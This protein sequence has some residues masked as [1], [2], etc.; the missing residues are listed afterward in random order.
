MRSLL[1]LSGAI[2]LC[3]GGAQAQDRPVAV[4]A[5]TSGTAGD[6]E[7]IETATL[8]NFILPDPLQ[9]KNGMIPSPAVTGGYGAINLGLD[10]DGNAIEGTN[11]ADIAYFD[12]T[13]YLYGASSACGQFSYALGGGETTPASH[14]RMCGLTIYSSDDLMNWRFVS[15]VMP[16]DPATGRLVSPGKSRVVYSPATKM[17][18]MWFSKGAGGSV[19]PHVMQSSTPYGPWS[20]PRPIPDSR[21]LLRGV[22]VLDIDLGSDPDGNTWMVSSHGAIRVYK[23]ND[24]KTDIVEIVNVPVDLEHLNGGIGIHH[25]NGWWYVTGGPSC[26]NC[27]AAPFTYVMARDPSGPWISPVTG[28]SLGTIQPAILSQDSGN[29]QSNG[30]SQLP[31]GKGGF[32]TVV[33]FKHYIATA[34]KAPTEHWEQPGDV[35][36]GL[37]G[38]WFY[39]LTYG[40]DGKIQPMEIK[41]EYRFPLA[42]PVHS[43]GPPP[44]YQ[45]DMSI[46]ENRFVEQTWTVPQDAEIRSIAPAVFQ[47]TVDDQPREYF[48]GPF[49]SFEQVAKFKRDNNVIL[50]PAEPLV[51]AP[52]IA[53]LELPD[54]TEE[55]W[56]IDPR[57]VSWSPR[58]VPLNLSRPYRGG[59]QFKL[60]LKTAATNGAY[61]VAVGPEL[62]GGTYT[63]AED[64]QVEAFPVGMALR[65]SGAPASEPKITAQPRSA[66]VEEG[67][68]AG[69]LVE[70][71][72]QGIGYQWLHNGK[73][74]IGPDGGNASTS[75]ALPIDRAS[76]DDAGTYVA[77]VFNQ[78]GAVYSNPVTLTVTPKAT[79]AR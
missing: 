26:A 28:S 25:E 39:P 60:T 22:N 74:I 56:T 38:L 49:I 1:W 50:R 10:V 42:K 19:T 35:N 32:R 9:G 57:T 69:F 59:G 29:A 72:G 64:E 14:N 45:A 31:D 15:R 76:V 20:A 33:P 12:G 47:R 18:N 73:I 75:L 65:T 61:G 16:Q 2:A 8:K 67:Q 3:L 6:N 41:P 24:E 51:N 62:P 58:S 44:A 63:H 68:D 70:A 21:N 37:M 54:G 13:Y 55:I 77:V 53:T 36:L 40:D 43:P 11:V 5:N 71:E 17:Y 30:S 79:E 34:D 78:A 46:N 66:T 23:L 27:V 52:L 7:I 48:T 4:A